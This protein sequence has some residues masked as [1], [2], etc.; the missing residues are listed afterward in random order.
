MKNEGLSTIFNFS[1]QVLE[2]SLEQRV[3][4]ILSSKNLDITQKTQ[5]PKIHFDK[6]FQSDFIENIH[7]QLVISYSLSK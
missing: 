5:Q 6:R 1:C 4:N 7:F 3:C 2:H